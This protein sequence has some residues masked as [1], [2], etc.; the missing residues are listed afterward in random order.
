M[1]STTSPVQQLTRTAS[2]LTI[3]SGAVALIFGILVIAFPKTSLLVI[4]VLFGL[5]LIITG[6]IRLIVGSTDKSLEGWE[7]GLTITFGVLV[8]IAGIFCLRNPALS[9][10]TLLVVLAIG[11]FIDGVM[12]IVIGVQNP[13]GERVWKIVIGVVY[14]LGAI[15]L[16]VSPVTS[17]IVLALLGG[18]ILLVFG[19]VTVIAG[20]MA[21]RASARIA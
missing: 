17:V 5:Q 19:V 4:G 15:V 20:I 16:L 13:K 3:V 8:A 1:S 6:I 21:M 18:W 2:I 12:H 10:L 11:W 9:I 14:V 7:K